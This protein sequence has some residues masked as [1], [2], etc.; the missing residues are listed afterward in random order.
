MA[1]V[2]DRIDWWMFV[3]AACGEETFVGKP[4]E[5]NLE[6]FGKTAAML[7]GDPPVCSSCQQDQRVA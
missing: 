7:Y 6:D 1:E 3:C 5:Q 4:P 2:R